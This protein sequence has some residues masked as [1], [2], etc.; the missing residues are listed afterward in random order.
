MSLVIAIVVGGP[1]AIG[2]GWLVWNFW[3]SNRLL[4]S[5]LA[6]GD[7]ELLTST[8]YKVSEVIRAPAGSRVEKVATQQIPLNQQGYIRQQLPDGRIAL[9]PVS[10]H[11]QVKSVHSTMHTNQQ[12][13]NH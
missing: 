11:Q 13:P 1:I 10:M 7:M 6:I 3:N 5:K 12:P 9:I 8:N 4:D 2:I